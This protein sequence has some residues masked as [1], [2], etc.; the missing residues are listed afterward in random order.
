[1]SVP[2]TQRLD[3][4]KGVAHLSLSPVLSTVSPR[5]KDQ[6]ATELRGGRADLLG[7]R[8]PEP[9]GL[10]HGGADPGGDARSLERN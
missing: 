2:W 1:M 6:G 3:V 4:Y 8:E 5:H 9:R 10:V 7:V